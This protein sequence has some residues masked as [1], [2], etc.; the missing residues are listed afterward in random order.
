MSDSL[1][2]FIL[3]QKLWTLFNS[4]PPD[5]SRIAPTVDLVRRH[6]GK[7]IYDF[8]AEIRNGHVIVEQLPA[9]DGGGK[10]EVAGINQKY[11]GPEEE[12]LSRMVENGQYV[13]AEEEA[14]RYI[15]QD[16][17]QAVSIS[18]VAAIEF[19]C[20][21]IIFNRGYSGCVK[22]LQKAVGASPDGS[23][24]PISIHALTIDQAFPEKILQDIH[25]ARAWYESE[26]VGTRSNFQQ[27]LQNRW[28]AALKAG[29]S[30]L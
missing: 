14:I 6:M 12:L 9:N 28:D 16:T 29:L 23:W 3:G 21:D 10:E 7:I 18:Q 13:Q 30:F 1:G 24:G 19:T 17:N 22:T 4:S 5:A 25:D 2:R 15:I 27:G 20:R 11:D 8:E 26:V